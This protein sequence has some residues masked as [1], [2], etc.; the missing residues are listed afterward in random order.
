MNFNCTF[1]RFGNT[2]SRDFSVDEDYDF[3]D[4]DLISELYDTRTIDNDGQKDL[5]CCW[6]RKPEFAPFCRFRFFYFFYYIAYQTGILYVTKE[7]AS[8]L[9][10]G[11]DV[12]E[13]WKDIFLAI[14][15]FICFLFSIFLGYLSD[16][17]GRRKYIRYTVLVTMIPFLG[18]L[19]YPDIWLYF[20]L[21]PLFG[22]VGSTSIF[23]GL[24]IT[25]I[26]DI[27]PPDYLAAAFASIQSIEGWA[28]LTALTFASLLRFYTP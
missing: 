22:F 28:G 25:Y 1:P 27:M 2:T 21:L 14:T 12:Y 15:S 13:T 5:P 3:G 16:T 9:K 11:D 6:Y 18:V 4:T 23:T 26:A 20:G 10:G 17:N 7:L 19:I 24:F 8:Q